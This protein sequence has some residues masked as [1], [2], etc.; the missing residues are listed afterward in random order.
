MAIEKAVVGTSP[1]MFEG[2][3]ARTDAAPFSTAW[4]GSRNVERLSRPLDDAIK[5]K[6]VAVSHELQQLRI[7]I[8]RLV[9][10]E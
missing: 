8:G 6:A 7:R 1:T 5:L 9:L 10:G 2:S 4:N 3:A